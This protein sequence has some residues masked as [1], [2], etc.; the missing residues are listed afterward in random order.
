MAPILLASKGLTCLY[1]VPTRIRSSLVNEGQL[2]APGKWSSA[3]SSSVR[4]SMMSLN[5]LSEGMRPMRSIA[6]SALM[7]C[8]AIRAFV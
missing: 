2:T 3:N 1:S 6:A 7:G 8:A 5:P 4:A